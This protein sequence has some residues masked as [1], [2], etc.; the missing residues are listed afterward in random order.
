MQTS[1]AI[2]HNPA[3]E[4]LTQDHRVSRP[5][6][7]PWRAA[8]ASMTVGSSAAGDLQLS[9][10]DRKT[11]QVFET[12][13][14]LS[15]ASDA[16]SLTEMVNAWRA[17]GQL[18]S[19]FTVSEDG[20]SVFTIAAR[21][22]NRYYA[23]EATPPGAMTVD[24]ATVQEPGGVGLRFGRFV[25][26]GPGDRDIEQLSATTELR[27]LYGMLF[28]TDAN[29][30]HSIE[31]DTPDAFDA[32]DRGK[33]HPVLDSG[34]IWVRVEDAVTPSTIPY[35]RRATTGGA[36]EVGGV[37]GSPDG[38][39]QLF[40]ATPVP[41]ETSY[42][43]RVT[44]RGQVYVAIA[45]GADGT[46]VAT[47]ICDDLR[48]SLGAVPGLTIGGTDTMTIQGAAGEPLTVVDIGNGD[49]GVLETDAEDVDTIDISPIASFETSAPA[50]ELAL[51]RV[52]MAA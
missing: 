9:A 48:A 46:Y 34:R 41:A 44:W 6:F 2:H 4:G 32:L 31:N 23:F 30:F 35:A 3:V 17:N 5:G 16:A 1:Y 28:R 11:G 52:R 43:L 18:N 15:G 47:E 13:V 21:N 7:L 33:T 12:T 27:D 14:P 25:A 49:A 36:G 22:P 42:G 26:R 39:Q 24:V 19:L 37:R 50:G 51:L 40:T 38:G 29:H 20:A 45:D 8:I 10:V